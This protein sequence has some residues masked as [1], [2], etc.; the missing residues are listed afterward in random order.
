MELIQVIF[1]FEKLTKNA[2]K[3]LFFEQK[4]LQLEKM[5]GGL[6][7]I[8]KYT[9]NNGRIID[10]ISIDSRMNYIPH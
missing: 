9:Y 1:C 8:H 10:S 4:R 6:F 7:Y 3:T 5:H 2:K